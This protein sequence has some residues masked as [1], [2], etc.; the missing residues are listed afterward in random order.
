M[1][2]HLAIHPHEVHMRMHAPPYTEADMC[3]V[4]AWTA[5]VLS[6]FEAILSYADAAKSAIAALPRV[7]FEA[8]TSPCLVTC[9]SDQHIARQGEVR[10]SN[11]TRGRAAMADLAASAQLKIASKLPK[12]PSTE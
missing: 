1:W 10:A 3:F 5:T 4:Y 7:M 2:F 8:L 9:C 12:H 6:V 11:M